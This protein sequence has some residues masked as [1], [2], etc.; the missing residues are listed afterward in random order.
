MNSRARVQAS[1][2]LVPLP[3]GADPE[4]PPAPGIDIAGGV[5][6]RRAPGERQGVVAVVAGRRVVGQAVCR[7]PSHGGIE[8]GVQIIV[9]QLVSHGHGPH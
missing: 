8:G 2:R 9:S 7:Q 5:G 1:R 4:K 6:E 3:V